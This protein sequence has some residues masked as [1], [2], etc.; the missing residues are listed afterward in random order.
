MLSLI[1]LSLTPLLYEAHAAC[2]SDAGPAWTFAHD[3]AR[4]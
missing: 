4:R 2:A 1:L 3:Q